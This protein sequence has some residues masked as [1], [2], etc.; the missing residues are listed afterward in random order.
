MLYPYVPASAKQ[1]LE[2]L[3]C[4][5]DW[6]SVGE[7]TVKEGKKIKSCI[8]FKKIDDTEMA[9]AK[10]YQSKYTQVS[11]KGMDNTVPY[12]DFAKLNLV[13]GTI[14][15]VTEHPEASKLY[16]LKVDI[17]K[18]QRTIVAGLRQRYKKEEI[19]GKQIIV[20]ENLEPKELR[21][22]R[23]YGMLLATE[24]GTILSPSSKVKKGSRIM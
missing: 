24:D 17:G 21:G 11:E 8:L 22:I 4:E 1:S 6:S 23:S 10:S 7:F 18:E 9:R 12:A 16:V 15:D 2:C 19:L 13:A 14:L 5:V 3:G 20:I